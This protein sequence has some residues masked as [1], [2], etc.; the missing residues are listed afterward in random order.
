MAQVN[1]VY[2][3]DQGGR[4]RIGLYH[5]DRSG[6]LMIHCNMRVVQIDFSVRDTKI[7]SFFVEDELCEIVVEK[8]K[9][10]HFG[11]EFRV[12][13]KIDTPRN[14]IRRID[15]RRNNKKLAAFVTGVVVVIAAIFFG[16]KWYGRGQDA[17]RMSKTSIAHNLNRSNLQRL[18]EQGRSSTCVLHQEV[19]NNRPTGVYT[20]KTADSMSIRGVFPV[21]DTGLVLLQNGFPLTAGDA[22]EVLYLPSDPEVHRVELFRPTHGTV[23]QYIKLALQEEQRRNPALSKEKNLCRVLTLAERQNW[24]SLADVIFQEKT[25][26]Q[27]ERHNQET[28]L[29]LMR[30]P[31]VIKAVEEGCWDK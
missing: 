6:H 17:L 5:G 12:N 7:Y 1:W 21:A 31:E 3:D 13:K 15:N 27:N 2:L 26:A 9:Q 30:T 22:F 11:Y 25:P 29:R 24:T 14:R 10:G 23:E 4:H 8:M 18:A 28:Y 19:I 20:F 16:L